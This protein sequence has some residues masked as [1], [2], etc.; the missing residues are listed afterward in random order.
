MTDRWL[1]YAEGKIRANAEFTHLLERSGF[2]VRNLDSPVP[3]AVMR[4]QP[5]LQSASID[6][7][8]FIH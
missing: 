3:S 6:S 4:D 7:K 8:P 2:W 1:R 5:V